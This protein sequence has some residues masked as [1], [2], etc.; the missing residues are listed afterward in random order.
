MIFSPATRQGL[1]VGLIVGFALLSPIGL[2]RKEFPHYPGYD[3]T[4]GGMAEARQIPLRTLLSPG[5]IVGYTSDVDDPRDPA[6]GTGVYYMTQYALAPALVARE[7]QRRLVVG[8]FHRPESAEVF[9]AK[10]NWVA[11]T[12]L[13]NGVVLFRTQAK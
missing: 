11:V 7:T 8:N 4:G 3:P 5:E 12:N 6:V 2:F 13:G 10:S 9:L 1:G